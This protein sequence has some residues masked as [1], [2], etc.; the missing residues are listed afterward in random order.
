[1]VGIFY[2]VI[3][4]DTNSKLL[5]FLLFSF[6]LFSVEQ[7]EIT[8]FPTLIVDTG[9][10][11]TVTYD[12]AFTYE[13]LFA[14]LKPF[15][16]APANSKNTNT[17]APAPAEDRPLEVVYLDTT[18]DWEK[19]ILSRNGLFVIALLDK[20]DE[21][22]TQSYL[23]TTMEV[24]EK[25]SKQ[26]RYYWADGPAHIPFVDA[27]YMNNGWPQLLVLHPKKK[28][29]APLIGSYTVESISQFLDKVLLGNKRVIRPLDEIPAF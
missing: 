9:N 12:G 3:W 28:A 29:V 21:Q 4:F 11:N 26:F 7:Y 16:K 25:Y 17:Q 13:A 8:K 5:S 27:L 10:G 14:F 15:A 24:A 2:S 23:A 6:F 1:M 19:E 22:A 20:S 18:A